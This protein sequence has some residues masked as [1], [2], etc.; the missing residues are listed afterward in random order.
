MKKIVL[1]IGVT[2]LLCTI[3]LSGCN[4]QKKP[5]ISTFKV[6][7]SE[8]ELGKTAYLLWNVTDATSV[9]IDNGIGA[10][11]PTGNRSITPTNTTIY[12]LTATSSATV[13]ATTTIT[14]TEPPEQSNISMIQTDFYIE[15]TQVKNSRILQSKV[16]VIA[17]NRNTTENQ[18][19]ALR[20]MINE[21]DGNQ[22]FLGVGDTIT[23]QNL[24]DF[25]VKELWDIQLSY[26]GEIISQCVFKNPAGP[27]DTPVVRMIQSNTSVTI[28]GIINGPLNQMLCS[29][30]AINSTSQVNQ[31]SLLGVTISDKDSNPTV[32]GISDQIRFSSLGKFKTGD[33]WRILL[34][35]NGD[36]IGQC[37]F[38]NP[39]G[40]I[41]IPP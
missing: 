25:S 39:G 26:N 30:T 40:I 36:I 6:I 28:Y 10:V 5:V 38:T 18:T 29:I 41:V 16:H 31:T 35:Y 1:A 2:V 17:I 23:F 33:Q 19:S 13:T 27:Y 24:S 20:P 14:V 3:A 9:T 32:L 7:P 8:I 15:I 21:G 37:T 22:T 4:E 34:R 11:A 12:T